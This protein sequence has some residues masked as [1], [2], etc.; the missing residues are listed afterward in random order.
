MGPIFARAG[1][2]LVDLPAAC[3][4]PLHKTAPVETYTSK[5]ERECTMSWSFEI[6]RVYNRGWT[7]NARL[8]GNNQAGS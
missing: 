4:M 8:V 1:V 6:G 5:I 2:R 7:F 3:R